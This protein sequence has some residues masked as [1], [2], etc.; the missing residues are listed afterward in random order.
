MWFCRSLLPQSYLPNC[1]HPKKLQAFPALQ[2]QGH[3]FYTAPILSL[4]AE[5]TGTEP[6]PWATKP[7]PLPPSPHCIP[8]LLF[9]SVGIP[10]AA[11]DE[12]IP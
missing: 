11:G 3:T 8:V 10:Q 7:C 6:L 1:Q 2:S 9:W 12:Q 5:K 4:R